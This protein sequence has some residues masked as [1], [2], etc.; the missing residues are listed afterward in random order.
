M[1]IG[2]YF[3]S[4]CVCIAVASVF[5]FYIQFMLIGFIVRLF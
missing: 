2:W 3:T 4:I 5:I 1:L